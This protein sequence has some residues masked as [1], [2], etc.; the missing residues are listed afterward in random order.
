MSSPSRSAPESPMK[1]FA[2]WKFHGRKPRATPA[3]IVDMSA[4]TLAPSRPSG[5]RGEGESAG[6][7]PRADRRHERG[8]PAR[9]AAVRGSEVGEERDRRDRAHAGREA[10]EPV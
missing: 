7:P 4:A 5:G 10:V 6:A 8:A 1:I 9:G 3:T 2:G